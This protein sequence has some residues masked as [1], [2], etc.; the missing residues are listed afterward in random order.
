MPSAFDIN[1]LQALLRDFHAITSIRIT[2]FDENRQELVSYPEML[3]PLCRVVRSCSPGCD[4]CIRSDEAACRKAA[5]RRTTHIYR[6]HAGMTEAITPLYVKSVLIGYLFFGNVFSYP[7][8]EEGI[9]AVRACC[10]ELPL[11]PEHIEAACR[12]HPLLSTDYV[13]SATHILH[14][15]ASYL[16][17]ERMATLHEDNLA[18]KLGAYISA[19]YAEPLTAEALCRRFSIGRTQLYKLSRQLYGCGVSQEIRRLRIEQAKRDLT[20]SPH[21]SIA[22]IGST[23]GYNDYNYFITVF[24]KEVGCAPNTYRKNERERRR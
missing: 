7:T 1:K 19:H 9:N 17:L 6:C 5:E 23:C 15:V 10:R 12:E 13:R 3:P 2:V 14:A 24:T 20:G 18:K 22:H 16:L 21:L 4:A 8:A 11:A